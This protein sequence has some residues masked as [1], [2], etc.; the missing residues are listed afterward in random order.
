MKKGAKIFFTHPKIRICLKNRRSVLASPSGG[1]YQGNIKF[2]SRRY[3][4][5]KYRMAIGTTALKTN[6]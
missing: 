3:E 4:S 5:R 2:A 1:F 6:Y